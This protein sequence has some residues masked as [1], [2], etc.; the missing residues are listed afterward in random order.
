MESLGAVPTHTHH[1]DA[2]MPIAYNRLEAQLIR[3]AWTALE[4]VAERVGAGSSRDLI[5][6]IRAER[7]EGDF[8]PTEARAFI[9]RAVAD[10][11]TRGDKPM[12]LSELRNARTGTIAA[13]IWAAFYRHRLAVIMPTLESAREAHAA[14]WARFRRSA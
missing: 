7:A 12:C 4:G 8:T 5:R 6:F 11:V 9:L 14:A 2:T 1:K 13:R 3:S 10:E